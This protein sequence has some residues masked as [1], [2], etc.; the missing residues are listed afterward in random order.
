M[1]LH[2][3][4]TGAI[5]EHMF[6]S[7]AD[8]CEHL[9]TSAAELARADFTT[10]SDP[11]LKAAA[12]AW[13]ALKERVDAAG[14]ALLGEMDARMLVVEDGATATTAR[15]R[16]HAQRDGAQTRGRETRGQHD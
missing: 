3:G 2:G 6:Q 16:T 10:C 12:E 5:L 4:D 8:Q 1:V 15:L 7:P 11:A 9:A 14:A 13:C